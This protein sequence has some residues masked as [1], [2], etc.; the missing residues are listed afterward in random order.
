[1]GFSKLLFFSFFPFFFLQHWPINAETC[2]EVSCDIVRVDF[3]FR[4]SDQPS[5]C[6]NPNFNL[7]CTNQ[8]QTKISFPLSGEFDV[9][10][11]GYGWPSLSISDP[12]NCIAK[13]LLG[14]LDLS[15]TPF[16]PRY[17]ENYTFFNCSSNSN[18][19]VSHPAIYFSCLSDK[20]FE[21]WAIPTTAYDPSSSLRLCLEISTISVPLPS[22]EYWPHFLDQIL[23]TWEEPDCRLSCNYC[24][25]DHSKKKR[26]MFAN[27]TMSSLNDTPYFFPSYL[28]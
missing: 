11:I 27:K 23:L 9:F 18:V 21:V 3:P 4:L 28:E 25:S 1:M 24:V 26:G 20:K 8:S 14:G 17:P 22:A 6:G 7:S 16:E 13:R 5:C 15:G 2:P 10:V 12:K 19:S